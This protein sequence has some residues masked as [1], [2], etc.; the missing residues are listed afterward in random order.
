M[1]ALYY[2]QKSEVRAEDFLE[3]DFFGGEVEN[4]DITLAPPFPCACYKIYIFRR[5]Q[6]GET[7][8]TTAQAHP[9]LSRFQ[10]CFHGVAFTTESLYYKITAALIL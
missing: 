3:G 7:P 1:E 10:D 8:F 5:L 4:E 9:T 2:G 6:I